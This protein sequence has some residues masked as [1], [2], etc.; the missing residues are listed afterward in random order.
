MQ[1][2]HYRP[3]RNGLVAVFMAALAIGAG[4]MWFDGGGFL[5]LAFCA[6]MAAGASKGLFD[7]MSN[8]PALKFDRHSVWVRKTWGGVQEVPWRDVHDISASVFTVR[9]AGLVPVGK[10][11]YLTITCEGGTF[12]AR[13]LRI[14]TTAMGLSDSATAALVLALKQ[15]HVDAVGIAGAAMAGAGNRGW[16]VDF[17]SKSEPQNG[18]SGFDPDAAL[19]RYLAS[20]EAEGTPAAPAARPAMPQ[21]PTFG[22]RVSQ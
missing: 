20:K 14:S 5:L 4:K 21:R 10:T 3:G 6:L 2:F 13:R 15:A 18:E 1:S 16:G 17:N 8:E 7:A 11:T 9:Y 22:R 19:E 12:G